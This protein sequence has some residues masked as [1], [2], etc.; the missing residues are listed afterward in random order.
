[1]ITFKEKIKDGAYKEPEQSY[2]QSFD[3]AKETWRK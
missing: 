2:H 3:L 1:M